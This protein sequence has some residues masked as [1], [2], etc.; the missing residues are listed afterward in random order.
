[1]AAGLLLSAFSVSSVSGS[2]WA[3]DLRPGRTPTLTRLVQLFL[4]Q[5]S[6]LNDAVAAR[7]GTALD[8]ML[9]RTFEMR[10]GNRPGVPVPRA[11][12]V[13]QMLAEN[14]AGFDLSQMAVH[15]KGGIALVSFLERRSDKP[16]EVFLVVDV[17]ENQPDGWKL[18][19]RYLSS[20]SQASFPGGKLPEVIDKRY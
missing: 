14:P 15:D 12:W 20:A 10:V 19:V 17:W 1:M 4:E 13:R 9:T 3:D 7:D 8:A 5:E 11:D 16:G 6:R 18:S 2:A